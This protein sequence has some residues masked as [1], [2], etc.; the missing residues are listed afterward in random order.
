MN[1][2]LRFKRHRNSVFGL[3]LTVVFSCILFLFSAVSVAQVKSAANVS[4]IK[5]GEEITFQ[6]EV[7]ADTTDLVVFPE[8]ATFLPLEIVYEPVT[9]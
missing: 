2:Y 7:E 6:I 5:I 8:G 9:F 4:E 3:P 1:P